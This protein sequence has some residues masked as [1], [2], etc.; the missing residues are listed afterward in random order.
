M[1]IFKDPPFVTHSDPPPHNWKFD[2]LKRFGD[3]GHINQNFKGVP[4]PDEV[5]EFIDELLA[6]KD[7][8]AQLEILNKMHD[9]IAEEHKLVAE[10]AHM[11][12]CPEYRYEDQQVV[13]QELGKMVYALML[14]RK[15]IILLEREDKKKGAT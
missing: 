13:F 8:R 2:F 11:Y 4:M 14:I 12:T 9:K 10:F 7:K 15:E 6:Q 5:I 1:S 3:F